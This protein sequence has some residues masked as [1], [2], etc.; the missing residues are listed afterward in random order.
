MS[1]R[2][3][4]LFGAFSLMMVPVLAC[5]ADFIQ[6]PDSVSY[7]P[8][9][10]ASA[11]NAQVNNH[12]NITVDSTTITSSDCS[13]STDPNTPYVTYVLTDFLYRGEVDHT[14]VAV[15]GPKD[16]NLSWCWINLQS[17]SKNLVPKGNGWDQSALAQWWK[18][19]VYC[20]FENGSAAT[21]QIV[22][23]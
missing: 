18:K 20:D 14:F 8:N 6:L 17:N 10:P 23:R 21:C 19:Q 12:F 11:F 9:A 3:G 4:I 5:A 7:I 13:T 2:K 1:T 16:R 22:T 15:Y